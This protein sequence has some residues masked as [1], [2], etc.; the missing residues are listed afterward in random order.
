MIHDP[1]SIM[2]QVP[3]VTVSAA[4]TGSATTSA[5]PSENN[6]TSRASTQSNSNS[7]YKHK[8]RSCVVCRSRKVRC[9]KQSP[10]SNC[11]RANIACVFPSTDRPPRWARRLERVANNA[12][13][14]AQSL[15]EPDPA[16]AHVMERLRH[17]ENLV[18]DLSNQLKQ[19]DAAS[20]SATGGSSRVN[21]PETSSQDRDT[22]H[23][24]NPASTPNASNVQKHF[25]RMVLQDANRSR[26]VSSGFWSRVKDEVRQSV[27]LLAFILTGGL[28][29]PN[30]SLMNFRWTAAALKPV[31]L[32]PQKTR[33]RLGSA[34]P[35]KK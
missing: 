21:S 1:N 15:Q 17:L 22:D 9:D 4:N 14:N 25:G 32:M 20:H 13:S 2:S 26:Y 24:K 7:P 8:L 19:A 11:R 34:R 12:A 30:Y 5:S 35:P 28:A 18:I 6:A 23:Q 29:N 33:P 3:P 16:A 27:A 10:C 31:I